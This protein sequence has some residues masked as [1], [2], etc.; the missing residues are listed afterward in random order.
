MFQT[1]LDNPVFLPMML[2][3]GAAAATL[4]GGSLVLFN[5]SP[6]PRLLAFG[7]AFAG[8][9]M[10][11]VSLTEI[12]Q[13]SVGSFTEVFGDTA[14]YKYGTLTLFIGIFLVLLLDR[15]IP[16]PHHGLTHDDHHHHEKEN[17]KRM[18][19]L[20]ALAIT[21]HNFPEGM[22]TFF[23]ALDD[24]M[25]GSTLALA[26]AVHNIPEGIAV[27]IPIYH[28]TNS[29]QKALLACL[30]SALAEPLGALIG[31]LILAPFLS[32]I[33][34]GAV[35]GVIA[36]VMIYVSLD[37]LLPSAKRYSKGHEAVYGMITG[38]ALLATSLVLFKF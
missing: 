22:A 5:K 21:A 37:E 6:S 33:V 25:I 7:L 38:M 15:L 11:Y 35:F 1:L 30:L 24:P 16:N 4:L 2:C 9:A 27:A 3:I 29:K 13:K 14:G 18:G 20:T 36:G 26:I 28:A 19:L 17:I 31:Y 32:P 23:A 10:I 8:G 34:Y 12:F